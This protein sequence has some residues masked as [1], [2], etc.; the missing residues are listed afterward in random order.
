MD[1][2]D[3]S[4]SETLTL[5]VRDEVRL[6]EDRIARSIAEAI[7]GL[8]RAVEARLDEIEDAVAASRPSPNGDGG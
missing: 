7:A 6:A 3:A 2:D 8:A 4:L 5:L 1:D